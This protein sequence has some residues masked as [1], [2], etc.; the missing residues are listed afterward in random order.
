[1][2]FTA[3]PSRLAETATSKPS[4]SRRRNRGENIDTVR[5]TTEL[6]DL[7]WLSEIC[8]RNAKGTEAKSVQ[9]SKHAV[10]ILAGG[11]DEEI[12]IAGETRM[13]VEGHGVTAYD[14]VL[15]FERVQQPDELLKSVCR[16]AKHAPMAF[17]ELEQQVEP[18]LGCQIGVELIV[19]LVGG[20][21]ARENLSNTLHSS[22]L[23][24]RR[25]AH[26]KPL[27]PRAARC[28]GRSRSHARV[29]ASDRANAGCWAPVRHHGRTRVWLQPFP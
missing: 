27:A 22:S 23:P 9:S 16:C 12:D 24:E 29:G 3:W 2:K 19:G 13:A 11:A 28:A 8:R 10:R 1:M 4:R 26:Q 5:G 7:A 14:E 25:Q 15:N 21:K 18:F 17:D 6:N 20:I